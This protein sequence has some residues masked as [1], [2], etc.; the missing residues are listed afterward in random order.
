[1]KASVYT[2]GIET[3]FNEALSQ[4]RYALNPRAASLSTPFERG[5]SAEPVRIANIFGGQNIVTDTSIEAIVIP[6]RYAKTQN[7]SLDSAVK[8]EFTSPY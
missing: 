6:E 4:F 5:V 7:T 3:L 1:M 2:E 8:L